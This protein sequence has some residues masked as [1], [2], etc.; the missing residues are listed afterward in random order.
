MIEKLIQKLRIESEEI[1]R[2][3]TGANSI[4]VISVLEIIDKVKV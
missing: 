2:I 3:M 1:I 4:H